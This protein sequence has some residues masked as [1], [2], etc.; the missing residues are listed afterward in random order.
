D[1]DDAAAV[2]RLVGGRAFATLTRRGHPLPR[3]SDLQHTLEVLE[4][5]GPARHDPAHPATGGPAPA[6]TRRTPR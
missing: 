2:E 5:L 3:V 1:R 4:R 6:P